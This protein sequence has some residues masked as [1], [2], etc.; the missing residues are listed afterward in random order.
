MLNVIHAFLFVRL[1]WLLLLAFQNIRVVRILLLVLI[2]P[3][4]VPF[5]LLLVAVVAAAFLFLL[6]LV[7]T[8][9]LP[10][11]LAERMKFIA[12][13]LDKDPT[14]S[15]STIFFLRLLR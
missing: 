1:H 11:F 9:D 14:S 6:L 12:V 8:V 13:F 7:Y 5:L 4:L 3:I 2:R 15:S 10:L